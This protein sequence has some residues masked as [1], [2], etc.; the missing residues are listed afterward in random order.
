MAG[1][2]A[3]RRNRYG[4]LFYALLPHYRPLYALSWCGSEKQ[5]ASRTNDFDV[6]F[7]QLMVVM[8]ARLFL[9]RQT[10]RGQRRP[11][12]K[13]SRHPVQL[14]AVSTLQT[15]VSNLMLLLLCSGIRETICGP[16][17]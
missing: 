14:P 6:T 2:G 13:T 16:N 7:G 12:L 3:V 17:S 4:R 10:H 1:R 11:S 5:V 9:K 8:T 15:A